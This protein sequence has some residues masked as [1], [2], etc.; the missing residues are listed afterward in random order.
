MPRQERLVTLALPFESLQ[1]GSDIHRAVT[2]ISNIQR[3]DTYGV[4]GNQELVIL[5][6]VEHE[7]EYAAQLFE[8]V[9]ALITVKRKNHLAVAS[10]LKFVLSCK[11]ATDILVVVN[12]AVDRQNLFLVRRIQRLSA[13]FRVDDAQPL[14]GEDRLSAT[15]YSTPVR[16]AMT[17]FL[18][19]PQCFLA[20]R[21]RLLLH[22]QYCYN[23]THVAM[24]FYRYDK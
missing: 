22:V 6:V 14:M 9:D 15:V 7:R 12:L 24:F 20:Q 18:T 19:H 5:N 21:R 16:S 13:T 11:S 4:T 10:R 1:L 2:I 3:D 8:E 17:Y 23:S